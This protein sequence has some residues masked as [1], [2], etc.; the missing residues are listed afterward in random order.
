M[1]TSIQWGGSVHPWSD[2]KVWGCI[3]GFGLL[4]IVFC[5]IQ[6][7]SGDKATLPPRILIKQRTVL[8]CA[9]FSAFLNMAVYTHIYYLPFY[10]QAVKGASAEGSG[11]RT[12]PYLISLTIASV[13][14]GAAVTFM[15]RYVPFTWLG[16]ALFTIGAG[17]IYT[18]KVTSGTGTWIGYQILA[19]FGAGTGVQIPFVAIQVVLNKKDMPT[20]NAIPIFFVSLGGAIS[21][22]IAQ[23][24]FSNALVKQ[25]PLHT[26]GIDPSVIIAAGATH[27]RDV[28]PPDQL[29]GV[30]RGYNEALTQAYVLAIACGGL[31][32]LS[33]FLFEWKNVKGK[34]IALGGGA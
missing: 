29:A 33:S 5:I 17:L 25:I 11:I 24:I 31:A 27:I 30:L 7:K 21:I 12:I 22:S 26:Q 19:G 14:V 23:N 34:N 16:S 32:F 4:I 28:T 6:V 3:L 18:L 9:L 13:V 20:G 1:L 8:A 15:G 2:S 10:F